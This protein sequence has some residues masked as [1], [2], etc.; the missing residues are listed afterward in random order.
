MSH[1]FGKVR[2]MDGEILHF[3]YSGTVDVIINPLRKSAYDV[4]SR[5]RK[6]DDYNDCKCGNDE[7]VEIA[8]D[9]GYGSWWRGRACKK[10]CVITNGFGSGMCNTDEEYEDMCKR[11]GLPLW[12]D[13]KT[14]KSI[15]QD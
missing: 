11:S 7:D 6:Y 5:W 13:E 1:A 9:Y 14:I 15:D 8:T 3:E 4:S 2:F 12:W 10:C